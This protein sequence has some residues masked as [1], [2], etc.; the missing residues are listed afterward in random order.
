MLVFLWC[1]VGTARV[2]SHMIDNM[3]LECQITGGTNT[4]DSPGP[5]TTTSS[6]ACVDSASGYYER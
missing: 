3:K 6:R 1:S 5:P 4:S 2:L